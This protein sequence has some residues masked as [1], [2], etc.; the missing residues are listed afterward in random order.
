M[1][2]DE[3]AAVTDST[4]EVLLT[5][6]VSLLGTVSRQ[7][8]V[9]LLVALVLC[10]RLLAA[11]D[12]LKLSADT[13]VSGLITMGTSHEW[14]V[15]VPPGQYVRL[16]I[17]APNATLTATLHDRS[18]K[19]V[20]S[21]SSIGGTGGPVLLVW[22]TSSGESPYELE[23]KLA[24]TYVAESSFELHAEEVRPAKPGDGPESVPSLAVSDSIREGQNMIVSRSYRLALPV[25]DQAL[26]RAKELN[27]K[28]LQGEA[29]YRIGMAHYYLNKRTAALEYLQQA[30]ALQ[31]AADQPY[32]AALSLNNLGIVR[33]LVGA[34]R[35]SESDFRQALA[36]RE[37]HE[38]RRGMGYTLLGLAGA[39]YCAGEAQESL[40][41]DLRALQIW[42]DLKDE[43][44]QAE[45]ENTLGL[46][47][48]T[49]GDWDA[50]SSALQSALDLRRKTGNRQGEGIST[51]N[52]GLVESARGNRH[53]AMKD[54]ESA[55]A[56]FSSIKDNRGIAYA[57][58]AEGEQYGREGYHEAALKALEQ[59]RSI[60][61]QLGEAYE[62][63]YVWQALGSE[64]A[65]LAR[66][67]EARDAY[68]KALSLEQQVGDGNGQVVTLS[69][70][71]QLNSAEP[72]AALA[73]AEKAISLVEQSRSDV[74][75]AA[76]RAT[77][78]ATKREIYVLKASLLFSLAERAEAFATSDAAHARSLLDE[79]SQATDVG[80]G[81]GYSKLA[82]V[83]DLQKLLQAD[84]LFVEYL[85]G[86][87]ASYGWAVTTSGLVEFRLP[88]RAELEA[89]VQRFYQ[90]LT[91]RNLRV[92]GETLDGRAKRI[93]RAEAAVRSESATLARV[94]FGP[95]PSRFQRRR[96]FVVPDGPLY[97]LPYALLSWKAD[98]VES[99]SASVFVAEQASKTAR[100]FTPVMVLANPE[101]RS[102][103]RASLDYSAQEALTLAN[104]VQRS[105][106][107][108]RENAQASSSA[109]L[110]GDLSKFGLIHIAAHAVADTRH[111]GKSAIVLSDTKV[112][113]NSIMKLELN[114]RLVTLSACDTAIGKEID[115]EG[116]MSL[117]RAFLFAGA[118]TVLSTLWPIDDQA[119]SV[120]MQ[121]FYS[122]LLK[123]HE[124]IAQSVR[125]AQAYMQTT[126]AWHD[127]YYWA[128]FTLQGDWQ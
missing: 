111:P 12:T 34:C 69:K 91:E 17:T 83:A 58:E 126:S 33:F 45:T 27:D 84:T 96:I 5:A 1:R 74:L 29:L 79:V 11:E 18:G 65:R 23:L 47:Y 119:T 120:F 112:D 77:Y 43:A 121:H 87:H 75:D 20:R 95:I 51:Y 49:M 81:K 7:L 9:Q 38:D 13:F 44:N 22:V 113:A 107:R 30:L 72:R 100:P 6:R 50:S 62:E 32:E 39:L 3:I 56:I 14:R 70:R 54:E 128:A 53:A 104:Y 117:G 110:K 52:M 60:L 105:E 63:G 122:A 106:I 46:V 92:E 36:I 82:S 127:P 73:D 116:V 68:A 85:T 40:D 26:T 37:S 4:K 57:L 76:H 108:I 25:L 64:Y 86:A 109:L 55:L 61:Q 59:S 48:L 21:T 24:G 98:V 16:K 10:T 124:S 66:A 123:K 115:G 19:A 118:H 42:R 15:I 88:P 101:V 93:V 31:Q 80:Q 89:H 103:N 94:L 71:A 90:A 102:G 28:R 35:E 41:A 125:E 114:T 99:P 67:D 78:L 97:L 2:V 8:L